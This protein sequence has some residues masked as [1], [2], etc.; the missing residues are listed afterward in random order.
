VL[1]R[2]MPERVHHPF[3]GRLQAVEGAVLSGPSINTFLPF[4]P[5]EVRSIPITTLFE[6]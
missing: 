6:L 2:N 4:M 5:A 3:I 1:D